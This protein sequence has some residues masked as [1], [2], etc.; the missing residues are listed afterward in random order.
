MSNSDDYRTPSINRDD[1]APDI[2]TTRFSGDRFHSPDFMQQ[3]WSK[4]WR[5]TWNMGPRLEEFTKVGDFI[6]HDLGKE[7]F[8]FVMTGENEVQGFYNVCQHRG[9]RLVCDQRK[10]NRRFF[11][12][13]FHAWSYNLDGSIK[14]VPDGETFPQLQ[15]GL[16]Q[17][18]LSLTPVRVDTWGGWIWFN[19]DAAAKPLLEYLD[20]L[21]KHIEPYRM[22]DM[23]TFVNATF[24]WDCNW[25]V[26]VD[27]FN[28]S[29][30]FRGIHPE[31]M[32]WS[33]ADAKLELLGIHSRMINEYGAPSKPHRDTMDISDRMEAYMRYFG[34]D[35][36]TYDGPARNVRI[37]KQKMN[38]SQVS[39]GEVDHLPYEKMSDEQLSDVYHYFYFPG[40]AQNIFPEGVNTFR[41][42]PH[43]TD[44]NKCYY[45][46]IMMGH[47]P[48]GQAPEGVEHVFFDHKI[49]Y[50]E[51]L[52]PALEVA[53][54][55]LQQDAD[56]VPEVQ[57]GVQ[58]E[59][60][61]GMYL[62]DQEIRVRHFHNIIDR[63]LE[64]GEA[65]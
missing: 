42:R 51:L 34:L 46:L 19:I 12:C 20:V 17:D 53:S 11:Q 27:A 62:G 49:Q 48:E 61:K 56:N 41:Y 33:N 31:M 10:G 24:L 4:L 64:G 28:E 35:P 8:I 18:A 5:R 22:E 57:Q 40:A 30:H 45:D 60:Y 52:D 63:Y 59:G 16:Q 2:G 37:E 26:A 44:P 6:I 58:S 7:S 36:A 43:E 29:Y 15:D 23:R 38:R 55:I 9:K 65:P 50:V 54:Y 21:P 14:G 3:E 13:A 32:M 1:P 25:K 39:R 47:F